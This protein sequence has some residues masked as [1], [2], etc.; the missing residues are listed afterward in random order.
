MKKML[1]TVLLTALSFYSFAQK[2]PLKFGDVSVDDLKMTRYEKDTAAVAVVLADYGVSNVEYSSS[3]DQFKINF[4]RITRIKILKTEGY[5]Y[6]DF[7]IPL[8]HDGSADEKLSALKVVTYNLEGGKKTES[9]MKSDAV[10]SEKYNK[11]I[12]LQKLSAPNVKQGSVIEIT[13]K[14][15]SD[16]LFN[17]KDWE[18]QSKIPVVWSEYRAVI[19]EYYNYEMYVQGYIP[20]T[21]NEVDVITRNINITST[22]RTMDRGGVPKAHIENS[23]ISYSAK[24]YRWVSQNVPAFVEEPFMTSSTDYISKINFELAYYKFPNGPLKQIMGTWED[25][26]KSFLDSEDFGKA[27][28]GSGFLKNVTES[29]ITGLNTSQEK[30]VAVYDF[31]KSNMEWDGTYRKFL[32]DNLKKPFDNKKGSSAEINLMLV[33]MLQKAGVVAN[34]V[35]VSTRD[36]GFVRE[37]FAL[38]SQFNYVICQATVEGKIILLD[39]TDRMLPMNILPERC[40]NGKGYV[41][42]KDTPGWVVLN[43]PKS[44]IS[45]TADLNINTDGQL[46]GKMNITRDGYYGQT[47]RI[48]YNKKGEEEY[49]KDFAKE[50]TWDVAKSEFENVKNLSQSVKETYQFT[51]Q[52]N[53]GNSSTLYINPILHMRQDE[54]PFKLAERTYPVD[55]GKTTDR[56]FIC[57]LTIPENYHAEEL[58]TS[59]VFMLPENA[60]RFVYNVQV[61]G[62]V[63]SITSMLSINRSL[64]TQNDY[65]HLREFYNMIVAKHA[66]QIVL[67]K[68]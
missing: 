3:E 41:I 51:H 10:F 11:N 16:F 62:N 67:K 61:T 64:F 65:P 52:E 29:V 33:S 40:L 22:E 24:S 28:D 12:N 21:T 14:I 58:P 48:N 1:A 37:S 49:V 50:M 5:K 56:T 32:D 8:Y 36:N 13:Y 54:N 39:A 25:M 42:S 2:A 60:A 30:L 66:E 19:P 34:P 55:F 45:S 27:V 4:E 35:L 63:I 18:F 17:F 47:M 68:N 44:K 43:S 57:K 38:S 9:K 7:E 53:L 15:S 6:A 23:S 46:T 26:N 20:I 31:V 59:K